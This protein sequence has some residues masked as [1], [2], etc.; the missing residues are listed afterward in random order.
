MALGGLSSLV[1]TA[2]AELLARG[3]GGE[4]YQRMRF[5]QM[6]I[7]QETGWL[8]MRE[9]AQRAESA[10]E[11]GKD[12]VAYVNLAR[13]AVEAACLDGIRLVQRSLGLSAFMQGSAAERIARDLQTYLRQPAPD[14][15]LA[16]AA[17]YCMQHGP[18]RSEVRA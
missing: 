7:A 13:T 18:M 15:V 6:T 8:W 12:A 9:A 3:R 10:A 5:G 17:S 16:E 11:P 4:A 2:R 1:A 14:E